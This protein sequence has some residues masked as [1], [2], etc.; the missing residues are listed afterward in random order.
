MIKMQVDGPVGKGIIAEE[1]RKLD[2]D[3]DDPFQVFYAE[4]FESALPLA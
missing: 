3:K 1:M 2:V 4:K